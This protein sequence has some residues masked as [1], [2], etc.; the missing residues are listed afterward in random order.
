MGARKH[1]LPSTGDLRKYIRSQ[2]QWVRYEAACWNF[3][4]FQVEYQ[5]PEIIVVLGEPNRLKLSGAARLASE[6]DVFPSAT[7]TVAACTERG[8]H[9]TKTFSLSDG[10]HHTSALTYAFHPCFGQGTAKPALIAADAD[11]VARYLTNLRALHSS[12]SWS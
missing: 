7:S 9:Q 5:R 8:L 1:P 6:W 11:R 12:R 3:L 4:C 2:D 10:S